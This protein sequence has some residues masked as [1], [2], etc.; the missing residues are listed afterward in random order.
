VEQVGRRYGRL[1]VA[2]PLLQEEGK[3]SAQAG[4]RVVAGEVGQHVPTQDAPGGDTPRKVQ[5]ENE[6][7]L[8]Q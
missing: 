1:Q 3:Q 5:P 4:V 2:L 8:A 6:V 7:G